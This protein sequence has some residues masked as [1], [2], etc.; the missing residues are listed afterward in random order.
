MYIYIYIYIYIFI[1]LYLETCTCA[2]NLYLET[3]LWSPLICKE[4]ALCQMDI[5]DY[6]NAYNFNLYVCF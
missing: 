6:V 5:R 3:C 1:Y 4:K 2:L